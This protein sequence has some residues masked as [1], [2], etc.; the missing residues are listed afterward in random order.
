[1]SEDARNNLKPGMMVKV[2]QLIVD[3]NSKGEEKKRIQMFEGIVLAV[4][5]GSE[6]G[7]TVTVRKVSNGVGVEKSSHSTHQ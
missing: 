5:H 7:A 4:K 3:V 2:H 6:P 1:M